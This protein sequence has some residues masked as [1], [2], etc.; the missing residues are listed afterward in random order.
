MIKK[1]NILKIIGQLI[2][3]NAILASCVSKNEE[4]RT[5]QNHDISTPQ[6]KT[7]SSI[8]RLDT[9][10]FFWSLPRKIKANKNSVFSLIHLKESSESKIQSLLRI[11]NT[12]TQQYAIQRAS[13]PETIM[14]FDITSDGK[15]VQLISTEIRN[16]DLEELPLRELSIYI[17]Q[18]R[19][20]IFMIQNLMKQLNMIK[21]AFHKKVNQSKKIELYFLC[22]HRSL[23]LLDC[24]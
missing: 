8:S 23:S 4:G 15:L 6:N 1:P 18:K 12:K 11:Y 14:D 3:L 10:K 2:L 9:E 24:W 21:M 20:L 19:F 13:S 5:L 22:L 16:P 17:D 7:V